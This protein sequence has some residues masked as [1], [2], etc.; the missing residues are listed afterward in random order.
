M[1]CFE[2]K[3]PCKTIPWKHQIPPAYALKQIQNASINRDRTMSQAWQVHQ[4]IK[5]ASRQS[6]EALANLELHDVPKPV[7]GP[8]ETLIRIHAG[9]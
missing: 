3:I 7:P 9:L 1:H 5:N 4:N 6:P 8:K 2:I